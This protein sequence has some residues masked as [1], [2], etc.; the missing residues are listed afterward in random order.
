MSEQENNQESSET[1][2]TLDTVAT[3]KST[4]NPTLDN[5]EV[6]LE[7]D[8]LKS[9][10]QRADVIGLKFH[11]NIG[12]NKLRERV[13]AQLNKDADQLTADKKLAEKEQDTLPNVPQTETFERTPKTSVKHE[14]P[15]E[16]KMRMHRKASR[17]IRIRMTCMNPSKKAWPGEVFTVSNSSAGT[18]RKYIPFNI[19]NGWHIPQ[20]M[21]GMLKERKF[22]EHYTAGKDSRGREIK[23]HRLV[24]E[25]AIEELPPLTKKELDEL[26]TQQALAGTIGK[27]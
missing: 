1:T 26:K 8:E 5:S 3:E 4:E 20:I 14:T 21:M 2:E 27:E 10:K 23:R 16:R 24:K 9:L 18:F 11:P 15:I 13:N 12:L 6:K 22:V 25:F 19:D 7:A 17:L